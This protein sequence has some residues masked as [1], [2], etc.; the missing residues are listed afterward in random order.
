MQLYKTQQSNYEKGKKK[1]I[2]KKKKT[3]P[4]SLCKIHRQNRAK[5]TCKAA[6]A[7]KTKSEIQK[8]Q[9]IRCLVNGERL[10]GWHAGLD[11]KEGHGMKD[12]LQKDTNPGREFHQRKA[13]EPKS[14]DQRTLGDT[15]QKEGD[16]CAR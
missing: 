1:L 8:K 11:P 16:P 7:S 6:H 5:F 9:K 10:I 12:S 3:P 13:L 2:K 14:N 15:L 4:L